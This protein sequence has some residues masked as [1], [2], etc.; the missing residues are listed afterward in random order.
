MPAALE[1]TWRTERLTLLG[2]RALWWPAQRSL[3]VADL[4]LGK[5][6]SFRS[7]GVPAPEAITTGDLDRL[8]ATIASLDDPRLFVLGDLIHAANGRTDCTMDAVA[9]WRARWPSLEVTVVR[10]NHDRRAGDPPPE[11]RFECVDG[12]WRLGPLSL[13]HEPDTPCEGPALAGHLHPAVSAAARTGLG[14]LRAPCF[15]FRDRLA[16]LPAFGAFTG[17]HVVRPS[18]GD[19]VFAVGDGAVA[20]MPT[21]PSFRRD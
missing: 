6:A 21:T 12:P 8:S 16:V 1:I 18:I 3:I 19:R 5:P 17:C 14:G 7:L 13:I 4:H 2:C 10:G 9:R 11:W 15:W 20:E